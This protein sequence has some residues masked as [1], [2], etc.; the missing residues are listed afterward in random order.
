GAA[1]VRV[2]RHSLTPAIVAHWARVEGA[3]AYRTSGLAGDRPTPPRGLI[4]DPPSYADCI[5]YLATKASPSAPRPTRGALRGE[6][7]REWLA[8]RRHVLEILLTYYW[9]QEEARA[10]HVLVTP[11]EVQHLLDAQFGS[12]RRF[13]QF[14]RG[15]GVSMSE[16]RFILTSKL[17]L[18]KLQERVSPLHVHT[19][20]ESAQM[21]ASVDLAYQRLDAAMKR[22]WI[23][24]TDCRAGYVVAECRQYRGPADTGTSGL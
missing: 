7:E 18:K 8:L 1:A 19:G 14:R 24:R 5:A 6:C 3:F 9:T 10:L 21:S 20:H 23:P 11:S 16:E 4:P 2:G 13:E 22:K 12:A 15:S 17:Q